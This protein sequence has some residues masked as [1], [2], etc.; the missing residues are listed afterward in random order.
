MF[1]LTLIGAAFAFCFITFTNKFN[2][3]IVEV[4]LKKIMKYMGVLNDSLN[5]TELDFEKRN[6][7]DGMVD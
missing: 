4:G 2:E 5:S 7:V 3:N 1:F 6:E